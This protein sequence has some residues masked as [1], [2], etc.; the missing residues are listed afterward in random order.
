[1]KVMDF[2]NNTLYEMIHPSNPSE[3][4]TIESTANEVYTD[5]GISVQAESQQWH[6]AIISV[7]EFIGTGEL[8][9]Y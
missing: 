2:S 8:A 5:V 3:W 9:Q 7:S 1:M 4:E 6:K